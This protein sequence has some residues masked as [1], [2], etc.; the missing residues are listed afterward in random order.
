MFHVLFFLPSTTDKHY[1]HLTH[2]LYCLIHVCFVPVIILSF[3]NMI[4]EW[5]WSFA[6]L[7]AVEWRPVDIR[8]CVYF[9]FFA[10][11]IQDVSKKNSRI[12]V[13]IMFSPCFRSIMRSLA[14]N[15]SLLRFVVWCVC[16]HTYEGHRNCSCLTEGS[17]WLK[18]N[19][20]FWKWKQSKARH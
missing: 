16:V 7:N 10:D 17:K 2:P 19:A 5:S 14:N 12:V 1:F 4:L 3:V 11:I 6:A 15:R 13:H 20:F 8:G 9:Y 18:Q